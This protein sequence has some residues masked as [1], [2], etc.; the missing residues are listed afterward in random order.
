MRQIIYLV[1]QTADRRLQELDSSLALPLKSAR[2]GVYFF[3][4]VC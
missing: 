1:I 4:E 3:I 2:E